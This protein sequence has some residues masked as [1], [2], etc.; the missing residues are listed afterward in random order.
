L[1]TVFFGDGSAFALSLLV[2]EQVEDAAKKL[3]FQV[4]A[5]DSFPDP[6]SFVIFFGRSEKSFSEKI[7]REIFSLSEA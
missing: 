2:T 4:F 6:T 1:G 3:K 7:N 5:T